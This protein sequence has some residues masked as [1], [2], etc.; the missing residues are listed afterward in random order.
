MNSLRVTVPDGAHKTACGLCH[1]GCGMELEIKDGE[2]TGVR[3]MRDHPL[4]K[5]LLCAKGRAVLEYVSSPN[6]LTS[7]LLK[8]GGG[9]KEIS[10][11]RAFEIII[12]QLSDLKDKRS[13]GISLGMPILLSGTSNVGLIRRFAHVFGTPNCFSVESICYRC[14]ML[15]YIATLG[16]FFVADPEKSGCIFVWG[17]N[18]D[19]SSPPVGQKIR[20]SKKNGAKLV[21]IDPRATALAK[22]ADLHLQPRPGTD[23]AL[24]LAMLNVIIS[25]ELYDRE[26]V[27][28]YT[29][30]FDELS[31]HVSE[32]TTEHAQEITSV[33]SEKIREAARL[34]A[35]SKSSCV[36]QGTN[37]L[38]QVPSGFQNSRGIAVLQAITGNVDI[39]G[40]F[41][42]TP[43]LR[44]NIVE[45]VEKAGE[46]PVGVDAYPIFYGI[47]GREFGEG[48]TLV[49]LDT[50][51]TGQPYPISK[52][53]ISGTNPVITWPES[54]KVRRALKSLDFLVVIEQHMTETAQLA[55]LVLPA[56]TFLERTELCDYYSL[57]GIPH[58]MLR[59]KILEYGQCRSDLDIWLELAHRMGFVKEFPW[60][61][62]DELVDHMLEPS[63]L[64]RKELLL[65]GGVTYGQQKYKNYEKQGFKTPSGKIEIY[66]SYLK[67]LSLPPLPTYFEPV[68]SPAKT[69]ELAEKY[70]FILT[71]GARQVQYIHSQLR[72]IAFLKRQFPEPLAEINPV[73]AREYNLND[74][75]EVIIESPR[76]EI[77][78]KIKITRDILPGVINIPHGWGR[79]NVNLLTDSAP[80]DPVT[81]YPALKALLCRIKKSA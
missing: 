13:L 67:D 38:D 7:P 8:E 29:V 53:I 33:P 39:P 43:R 50:L 65:S 69:P 74:Q 60:Q 64:S 81:G 77:K 55:H 42:Q 20:E 61:T 68:E 56:G 54:A 17:S 11:E 47:Y 3:G 79:A 70:P 78:I 2:I 80:V 46:K 19:H 6:R 51:L 62:A 49:M 14:R 25:E 15:G 71:T 52:M 37:A 66:S 40:G 28:K 75:D 34:F 35:T 10:W 32:F 44:V 22:R 76:G 24:I 26:F 73:T 31:D 21:V 16:R 41:I 1:M 63:G 36:V 5:G 27:S 58:V 72:E 4:N 12:S 59:N 30:G 18:P 57:W 9:W 48:Q 45:V 23:C